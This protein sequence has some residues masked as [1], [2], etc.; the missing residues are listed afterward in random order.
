M[1]QNL[2]SPVMGE[3]VSKGS[4]IRR[5]FD[6]G[7]EMKKQFGEDAVCDFSLGNP[8]LAPPPQVAAM[9]RELADKAS[10]PAS[11]GYMPNAGF[12]WALEALAEYLSAEQNVHLTKGDVMLSCGAAGA[13]NAFLH[14][15]LSPGDEVLGIAPYFVEYGYYSGNHGGVFK[16][17]MCRPE[18]FGPDLAAI[19]A[20]LTPQTRAFIINSPNNPSGAVYT[21]EDIEGIVALLRAASQKYGRPIYL[22]SD[23]PY[24]FL[25]YDGAVVPP[26]LP[27]Y[28]YAV[29][30][31]SFSK[32]YC[33]AG[34]RIGYVALSPALEGRDKLMAGMVMSNRVLG[35]VNPPIV[36]QY[37]MKASLGAS[38]AHAVEVYT[39][40][41]NA[42]AEILKTAGYEFTLPKGAFYFFPKA[43]GGKESDLVESLKA[44]R[45]LVSP[46][47]G[48]GYPGYFR[49]SFAVD[50]KI[51][52][53]SRDGFVKALAKTMFS[54]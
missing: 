38:T 37:L 53:R 7:I 19:E 6:A 26:V 14:S 28:E 34:E 12:E 9:L 39:R 32:N 13:L 49:I 45:V 31:G 10:E 25:T 2:L 42:L 29:V 52:A 51:I 54:C 20:A 8:D 41:R 48:F 46:G 36:G 50:D 5:M 23:E 43:P 18:D 47:S 27:L 21:K 44:E 33:L 16:P 1:S 4:A 40:R 30:V 35:Y 24:R 15:V 11:L 17:T 3:M 22:L